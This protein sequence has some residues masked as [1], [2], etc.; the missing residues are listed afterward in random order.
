M[1]AAGTVLLAIMVAAPLPDARELDG[2]RRAHRRTQL[3][4]MG[5]LT[6]W[7]VANIAGGIAG[8]VLVDGDARFVHEANAAWNT[9]N[10]ALGI[11]GLVS[12]GRRLPKAKTIAE[13]RKLS[14]RTMRTYAVNAVLDVVYIAAG[15]L[16]AELGRQYGQARV[17]G[18]GSA[19]ILQGAWLF[20]FDV[21]MM[22]AHGRARAKLAVT[23]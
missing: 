9:V 15:T 6:G 8:A 1:I 20:A 19:V 7:A 21:G 13:A 22:I 10:L 16:M 18:Y 5:V 2:F 23:R 11:A 4:G 17:Q 14:R 3:V 12:N